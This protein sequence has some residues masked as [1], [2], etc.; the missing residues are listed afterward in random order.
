MRLLL[1]T[2][3][4][5]WSAFEPEQLSPKARDAIEDADNEV[6]VSAVSAMEI[7]IKVRKGG[8][9]TARPLSRRFASQISTFGFLALAINAEHGELAGNLDIAHRDPWDRLLIAQAKLENLILVTKDIAIASSG[10][11]TLW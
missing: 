4:L 7:A 8:F 10:A 9:E 11:M 5:V 3:T 6:F 1:D 2:H